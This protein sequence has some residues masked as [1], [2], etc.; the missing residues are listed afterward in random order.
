MRQSGRTTKAVR[1]LV[2]KVRESGCHAIYCVLGHKQY[3][4][5]II[6]FVV[7]ELGV[8]YTRRGNVIKLAT[9][10]SITLLSQ[11]SH[12]IEYHTKGVRDPI[13]VLDHFRGE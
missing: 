1:E 11:D 4:M 13:I 8:G 5:D 10:G 7:D 3:Y 2:Q 9:G 12:S 6:M